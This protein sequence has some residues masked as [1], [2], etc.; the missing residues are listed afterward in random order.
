MQTTRLINVVSFDSQSMEKDVT[1]LKN[2]TGLAIG[3]GSIVVIIVMIVILVSTCSGPA[4]NVFTPLSPED[5]EWMIQQL[6]ELTPAVIARFDIGSPSSHIEVWVNS[7]FYIATYEGKR[8]LAISIYQLFK[9]K[10]PMI[11]YIDFYDNMTGKKVATYS[12][13]SGFEMK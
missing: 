12:A 4:P 6:A 10:S 13:S 1:N 9:S 11:D 8:A 2:K 3:C 5:Q 7:G